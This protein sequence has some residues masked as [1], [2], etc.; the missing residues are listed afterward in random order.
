ML[1]PPACRPCAMTASTPASAASTAC[2]TEAA[3]CQTRQPAA[4]N[5]STHALGG[6]F[7]WNTTS[8]T[9][10]DTHTSIWASVVAGPNAVMSCSRSTPKRPCVPSAIMRMSDCVLGGGSTALPSTPMPPALDTAV[11]SGGY[12]TN[13][14]PALT[15]GYRTPYSRVS[16]V[17]KTRPPPCR[18]V[19]WSNRPRAATAPPAR[20]SNPNIR[21]RSNVDC[22]MFGSPHRLHPSVAGGA[23][24]T[25]NS[26][27]V[28]RL[29]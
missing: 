12:E 16:R 26:G 10:S 1:C 25:H 19:S 5:V 11:T 23:D 27:V 7:M 17:L 24:E 14:I 20:P 13:P 21:R 22:F 18:S 9:R 8:F 29:S 6:T 2:S 4:C 28:T 15:N 3:C